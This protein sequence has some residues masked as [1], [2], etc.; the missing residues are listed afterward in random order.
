MLAKTVG[1][2]KLVDEIDANPLNHEKVIFAYISFS[3]YI[4]S[5]INFWS[6]KIVLS[7]INSGPEDKLESLGSQKV[8]FCVMGK[9]SNFLVENRPSF[10]FVNFGTYFSIFHNF[11]NWASFSLL[12]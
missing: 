9:W 3:G 6:I 2:L 11:R 5:L 4:Y 7:G 12:F 1:I 8:D 10:S